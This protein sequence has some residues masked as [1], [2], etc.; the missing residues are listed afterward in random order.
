MATI[1]A[2]DTRREDLLLASR[3]TEEWSVRDS[4]DLYGLSE[5]GKGYFSV[6]G[7]GNLLVLPTK[8]A[9]RAIDLHKVILGL[10]ERGITTPI[11][12][13][14]RDMVEH[15]LREIRSAF[16]RA[17]AEHQYQSGYSCI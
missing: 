14:F 11:I 10:E 5:W 17:I 2:H 13:R 12:V 6:A 8:D 3:G 15:R 1:S 9:R 7:S 16:D 4:A